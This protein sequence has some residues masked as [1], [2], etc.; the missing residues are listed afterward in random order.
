[1]TL[2]SRQTTAEVPWAKRYARR[3]VATDFLV[4]VWVVFGVQIAWFGFD[5]AAVSGSVAD[6]AIGYTAVSLGIIVAWL[7]V[8]ALY[9]TRDHRYIGTGSAEYRRIVDASIRLFAFVAIVAYVFK[10]DLARGYVFIAFPLGTVVLMFSR[11]IWRQWLNAQRW[12]GNYS[13]QVLLVGSRSSVEHLAG[14]LAR[15]P[16]EGYRVVAVC[17][18]D[19]RAGETIG[20]TGV[21]VVGKITD[22]LAALDTTGADTVAVTSS[23]ELGA[24]AVRELSWGL[25]GGRQHLI[26]APS[27]TQINGPRIHTRPVAGLP[28]IHVEMPRYEGA[29]HFLKRAFDLVGAA[30]LTAVLSPVLVAIAVAVKATSAGP[31]LYRQERIGQNGEPFRMLKFRSMR[32][33]ADAELAALLERQGTSDKPLF[34]VENDPRVTSIGHF[35]RKHSLDEFPQLFNVLLGTMSLVGP[36]PQREG[37]VA[38][39]DDAARRRLLLKPGMSGLWQVGGRSSLGWEDAIRLDLYYVENWSMTGDMVILWRT[40]KAVLRPGHD[41]H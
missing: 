11:W 15:H 32:V 1:M 24:Q 31:V 34:K 12:N 28:L 16:E 4:L 5:S 22:A 19:G 17:V 29:T 18:P 10:V 36:R 7:V 3:L 13:A 41:A 9:D 2:T 20:G 39:Y 23:E 27:L 25:E 21:P 33:N 14:E 6:L 8:L 35:L 26:V 38:L 40:V 37:E 30:L